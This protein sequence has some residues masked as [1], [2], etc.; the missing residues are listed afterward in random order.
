MQENNTLTLEGVQLLFRNFEGRKTE[1]NEAG[2]RNFCV[3]LPRDVAETMRKDG[4]NIKQRK[5]R[6]DESE[7]EYYIQVAVGFKIRPPRLTMINSVSKRRTVLDEETCGLL[8]QAD[9]LIADL[10]IRARPW[11]VRNGYG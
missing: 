2:N 6:D 5:P 7:P 10:T 3:A 1:Y 4:W 8:D 9:I 11:T